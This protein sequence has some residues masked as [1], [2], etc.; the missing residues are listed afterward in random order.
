MATS[1]ASVIWA[2]KV[3]IFRRDKW[4][5]FQYMQNEMSSMQTELAGNSWKTNIKCSIN[6]INAFDNCSIYYFL[7]LAFDC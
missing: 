1:A 2:Q 4:I 6:A 3:E 7:V 5:Y